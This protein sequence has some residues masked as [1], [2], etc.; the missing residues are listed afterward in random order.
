MIVVLVIAIGVTITLIVLRDRKNKKKKDE[1]ARRQ[2]EEKEKREKYQTRAD[3]DR[4]LNHNTQQDQPRQQQA[5]PQTNDNRLIENT[6]PRAGSIRKQEEAQRTSAGQVNTAAKVED[7]RIAE[8]EGHI[9][10]DPPEKKQ[11]QAQP[12]NPGASRIRKDQPFSRAQNQGGGSQVFNQVA[13][14]N[15]LRRNAQDDDDLL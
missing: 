9:S 6:S 14:Q 8:D 2:R 3:T 4:P 1:D 11:S 10:A 7:V 13:P 5:V 15:N 12:D